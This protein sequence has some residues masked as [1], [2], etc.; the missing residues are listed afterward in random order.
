M[1]NREIKIIMVKNSNRVAGGFSPP[2]PMP[3]V[4][5]PLAHRWEPRYR[6]IPT[7]EEQRSF[8]NQNGYGYRFLQ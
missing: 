4:H 5:N 1:A 8:E 2:A 7:G 6:F 3:G